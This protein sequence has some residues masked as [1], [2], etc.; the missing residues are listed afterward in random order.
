MSS[1][2]EILRQWQHFRWGE[3][4]RGILGNK[5]KLVEDKIVCLKSSRKSTSLWSLVIT[6]GLDFI[7]IVLK[8]YL[9]PFK[10]NRIVEM[11]MYKKAHSVYDEIMP[12]MYWLESNVNN[13]EI[14][15]FMEYL[16]PFTKQIKLTPKTLAEIIPTM[17]KFHA[18]TFEQ[19]ILK[20]E[21]I[22]DSWLPHYDS[23]S[24]EIERTQHIENTIEHLEQAIKEP[25]LKEIVGPR[26]TSLQKILKKGPLFFPEM[27]EAGQCLI[28]GDL[29]IHN[30]C[31]RNTRNRTVQFIDWESAK[32]A[33]CWY[34]LVVLVELLIDFRGDWHKKQDEI[35]NQCVDLYRREMQKHGITFKV[36]PLKLMKM[37]YLQRA[38]EKRLLNHLRRML[39]GEQSI[40]INR[41]LEKIEMWGKE[42]GLYQ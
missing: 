5:V 8:I 21:D 10:Q 32:Y 40:L 25:S 4:F 34:D 18:K 15:L 22:F 36:D 17:A 29:H 28:H 19:R 1:K 35:R 33:P 9:P 30:I 39:N 31:W 37:T 11:N 14:W 16:D 27:I 23:K 7:P 13:G 20:Y 6:N 2:Q 3:K 12:K 41:Y 38:L 26:Y 42:L 24:M